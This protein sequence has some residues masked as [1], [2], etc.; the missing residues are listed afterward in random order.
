MKFIL[1]EKFILKE[2]S[3]E[4]I[5]TEA[6]DTGLINKLIPKIKEDLQ[7]FNPILEKI[8]QKL[9]SSGA[10]SN[11]QKLVDNLDRALN[12]V[13]NDL[14][15]PNIQ[16]SEVQESLKKYLTAFEQAQKPFNKRYLIQ[17]FNV[18]AK[19]ALTNLS[20]VENP[21][22]KKFIKD[23]NTNLEALQS[24]DSE[25]V[26]NSFIKDNSTEV[27][28]LKNTIAKFLEISKQVL[29]LNFPEIFNEEAFSKEDLAEFKDCLV[30]INNSIQTKEYN[31]II[32]NVNG[33]IN[34]SQ[35]I[36]FNT[37]FNNILTALKVLLQTTIASNIEK[38][39]KEREAEEAATTEND[40]VKQLKN[41]RESESPK[42]EFKFWI[43]YY[44]SLNKNINLTDAQALNHLGGILLREQ[45]E[46][47]GFTPNTNPYLVYII[48]F[49]IPK[50]LYK[51]KNFTT[52]KYE[53]IQVAANKE[54]ID[55]ADLKGSK[56]G[57]PS[58]LY[59]SALFQ[60]TSTDIV[61]YLEYQDDFR[62][63]LKNNYSDVYNDKDKHL[64]ALTFI[65][66]G[67]NENWDSQKLKS[68]TAVKATLS[69]SKTSKKEKKIIP[70]NNE[71]AQWLKNNNISKEIFADFLIQR[72]SKNSQEYSTLM[73]KYK[74]KDMAVSEKD[75]K[76][77]IDWVKN[78][79]LDKI[80]NLLDPLFKQDNSVEQATA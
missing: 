74:L 33:K 47:F 76:A 26:R 38:A 71:L 63:I 44:Q 54:F 32:N 48:N 56:T 34:N 7:K 13:K 2:D 69:L 28:Q 42:A 39:E 14:N 70:T 59:C 24:W 21:D 20:N 61:K 80:E 35:I 77:C 68:L 66:F 29:N 52:D 49:I 62:Y 43:H 19:N 51:D 64:K 5:L 57:V 41:A 4:H 30:K 46:R 25:E 22:I 55:S 23:V 9:V 36:S 78:K 58:L 11:R 75:T 12:E 65:F 37:Y 16:I 10:A 60:N 53:A 40:W 6:S 1:N 50:Q 17:T 67:K 3:Q 73:K 45:I 18:R 79:A 72:N 27:T 31:S 8:D 15:S